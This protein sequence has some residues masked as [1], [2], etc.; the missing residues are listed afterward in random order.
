MRADVGGRPTERA[1]ALAREFHERYERLAPEFDYKTREASAVPWEDVPEANRRLMVAVCE[2]L[3]AELQSLRQA[4]E[5]AVTEGI[6]VLER[7]ERAERE[8]QRLETRRLNELVT[9]DELIEDLRGEL[10]Q[11]RE[12][13]DEY[14]A[15]VDIID[16]AQQN[17]VPSR[18]WL[19]LERLDW[20]EK[21]AL[22][23]L[24]GSPV[25]PEPER[26]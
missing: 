14:D 19:D 24:A 6:R 5:D 17:T 1:E 2:P 3:A 9:A 11:L 18:T 26:P 4:R 8:L 22:A 23:A 15:L 16:I 10:Q 20:I 13:S 7:A 12:A 21:R 25:V